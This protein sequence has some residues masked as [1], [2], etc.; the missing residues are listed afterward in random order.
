[1]RVGDVVQAASRAYSPS[2]GKRRSTK[3][4]KGAPWLKTVLVQ[5]AWCAVRVR[6]TYLR[7]SF[8]RLKARRGLRKAIV[9]A[10]AILT[11]VYWMLTRGVTYADLG[12]DH[13]ERTDRTHLAGRL[14]RKLGEFSFDVTWIPKDATTVSS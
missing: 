1:V 5:T 4:R 9:A 10:A 13:F 2:A 14:A 3:L 6:A 12:A 8:G 7:A 11:A